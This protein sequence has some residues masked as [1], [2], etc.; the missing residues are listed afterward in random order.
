[1]IKNKTGFTL[2][3]ILVVI[4]I[5]AIISSIILFSTTQYINKSK[6]ANV[7][8]NLAVLISAGEVYYNGHDQ[9]YD[10][11]CDSSV[12]DNAIEQMPDH[13]SDNCS[14]NEAGLCCNDME[15]EWA[16]CAT[17][18]SDDRYAYC[19]DSRGAKKQ[20]DSDECLSTITQCP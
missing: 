11:F 10:D 18:F 13:D 16:A 15:E 20:L 5:V 12:V 7:V 3:E 1:M 17:I 9:S 14:S 6:D 4:A 8:G 19:V 2:I